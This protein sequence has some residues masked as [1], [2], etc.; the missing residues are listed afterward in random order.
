M[1]LPYETPH[2]PAGYPTACGMES[3]GGPCET[4]RPSE[5]QFFTSSREN[6]ITPPRG[7]SG[8]N[9]ANRSNQKSPPEQPPGERRQ[10]GHPRPDPSRGLFSPTDNSVGT[11][12]GEPAKTLKRSNTDRRY[13]TPGSTKKA[14]KE[15]SVS[16]VLFYCGGAENR[17]RVREKRR[18]SDRR[19]WLSIERVFQTTHPY[20]GL[21]ECPRFSSAGAFFLRTSRPREKRL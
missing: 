20:T 17:E 13:V 5:R 11:P 6:F 7:L 10:F 14:L 16:I 9:Q 21:R 15:L 4:A 19:P 3:Q 8:L 2:A 18:I 12:V 1:N